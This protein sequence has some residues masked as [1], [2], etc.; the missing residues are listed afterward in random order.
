MLAALFVFGWPLL[1]C[2]EIE[3]KMKATKN[4]GVS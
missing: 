2:A 4:C 3:Y 1:T